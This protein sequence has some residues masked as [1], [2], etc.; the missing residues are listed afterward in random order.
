[1]PLNDVSLK[2]IG[3]TPQ[4]AVQSEAE[5]DFAEWLHYIPMFFIGLAFAIAFVMQMIERG[6][7][8]EEQRQYRHKEL[9]LNFKRRVGLSLYEQKEHLQ[10]LAGKIET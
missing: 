8:E 7:K 2:R 3:I 4:P 5:L 10:M 1:M 9:G 6:T